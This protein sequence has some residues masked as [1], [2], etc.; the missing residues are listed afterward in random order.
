MLVLVVED[1]LDYS[2]IITQ[3]LRR[4]SLDVVA[5]DSCEAARRFVRGRKPDAAILDVMLPDGTGHDL[6]T[7]LRR[8]RPDLPVLFLSSLDRSSDIVAGLEAG[9]D[10]Y[11]T[12]PFHPA[13]LIAR[14]RAVLRRA[15]SGRPMAERSAK[16][17]VADGLEVDLSNQSAYYNGINLNCTRLELDILAELAAY[18]GQA[19]SHAFLSDRV[20]GYK[21]VNDATLLKGHVSSIR[22]KLREAGASEDLVRTVHGVGYAFAELNSGEV[23]ANASGDR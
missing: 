8:S 13:E 11:L 16:R 1:D 4:D 14:L 22:R 2:D 18:P 7:E 9:G 15:G 3:T 20:W 10:D 21:N 5:T 12:K 17:I 19:L 23:M 6:C